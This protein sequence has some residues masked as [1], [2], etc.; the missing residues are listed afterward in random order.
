M[1]GWIAPASRIY[2]V[3]AGTE[4][5]ARDM[6]GDHVGDTPPIPA[7]RPRK[8][9]K[10]HGA[11]VMSAGTWVPDFLCFLGMADVEFVYAEARTWNRKFKEADLA[12]AGA[13]IARL[14]A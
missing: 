6:R 7:P 4:L 13:A 12:K 8:A 5:V 1:D 14:A 9:R 3:K 10:A 2:S 11:G